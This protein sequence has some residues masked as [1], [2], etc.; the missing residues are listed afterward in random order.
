MARRKLP[1]RHKG[2]EARAFPTEW[3]P[4]LAVETT[5]PT[6]KWAKGSPCPAFPIMYTGQE[7]SHLLRFF[8]DL[9]LFSGISQR[10]ETIANAFVILKSEIALEISR[11]HGTIRGREMPGHSLE[12][13]LQIINYKTI[14][15]VLDLP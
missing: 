8:S 6:G 5:V 11:S 9:F 12:S 3:S 10:A 2:Q 4:S 13:L 7:D 1:L 14:P 15:P